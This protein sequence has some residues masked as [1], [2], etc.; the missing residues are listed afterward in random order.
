MDAEQ[1]LQLIQT[2]G[3]GGAGWLI[4]FLLYRRHDS[5]QTRYERLLEELREEEKS[6]AEKA[7]TR[8]IDRTNDT[9]PIVDADFRHQLKLRAQEQRR[10]VAADTTGLEGE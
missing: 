6:R 8:L 3:L 4:A 1:F 5:L 10:N 2:I 7:E 9:R